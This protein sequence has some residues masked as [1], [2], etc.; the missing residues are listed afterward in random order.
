MVDILVTG[1][2]GQ[3]GLELLAHAW[4][5]GV[6]LHAPSRA[7]LDITSPESV[8]AIMASRDWAAVINPAAYTAVDKAETELGAAFAINALGPALLAQA[9]KAAGIP[10]IHVSTDYVFDGS[11]TRPYL[12]TDAIAPIGAYGAS[13]AAGELAVRSGNPR[14]VVLRTAWVVSPHRANFAKTMLRLGATRDSLGVVA[15]QHGSPTSATDIA[16]A[17]ATITLRLIGSAEA[18]TGIY[19]FTNAGQTTWHGFAQHIFARAAAAGL[20]APEVKPIGTSDYPTPARRPA[21]SVLDT[22][23][24]KRDFGIAPRPWQDATGE[25]VDALIHASTTSAE[26]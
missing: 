22:G 10:L 14:S 25:T 15:D 5:E 4:P 7:E 23:S 8:A 19:H 3:V 13:K 24:L 21:Y 12:P 20:K 18:P 11:G 9:T 1:G 26:G 6:T 2:A 16:A 17:L